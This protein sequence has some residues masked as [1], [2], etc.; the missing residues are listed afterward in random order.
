M[1]A[2][3][4]ALGDALQATCAPS[5]IRPALAGASAPR[6][7][8]LL[9]PPPSVPI[10]CGSATRSTLVF[11]L[12]ARLSHQLAR[13]AP[14][15]TTGSATLSTSVNSS[16]HAGR[17]RRRHARPSGRE[18]LEGGVSHRRRPTTSAPPS[19]CDACCSPRFVACRAP[20]C[21]RRRACRRRLSAP[22]ARADARHGGRILRNRRRRRAVG[23][24]PH[25][26]GD[27]TFPQRGA[28]PVRVV[29]PG[30]AYA[31]DSWTDAKMLRTSGSSRS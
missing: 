21:S 18:V 9:L 23:A 24:R 10:R 13:L 31:Y 11:R 8:Y 4:S 30:C 28:E 7:A 19:R 26:S 14:P 29:R 3:F 5:A 15:S 6:A 16:I 1:Q 25:A 22:R 20:G 2:C 27:D 17:R 12:P